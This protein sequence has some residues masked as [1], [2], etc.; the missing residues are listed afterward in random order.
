[1]RLA[2]NISKIVDKMQQTYDE[3]SNMQVLVISGEVNERW[4]VE[5]YVLVKSRLVCIHLL[6][7][8]REREALEALRGMHQA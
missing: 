8:Y 6:W 7:Q 5:Q 3:L 1:M 4:D 2:G